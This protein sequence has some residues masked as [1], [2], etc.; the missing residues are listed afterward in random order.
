MKATVITRKA[1]QQELKNAFKPLPQATIQHDF[2][3]RNIAKM[4]AS[5]LLE[6]GEDFKT[7]VEEYLEVINKLPTDSKRALH[8]AYIF[9]RKAPQQERNDLY[10]ELAI[11]LLESR[12][13]NDKLAYSIARCDWK[14]WWRSFKLRNNYN[15]ESIER[16]ADSEDGSDYGDNAIDRQ[17]YHSELLVGE[18]E[19][20]RIADLNKLW[21]LLPDNIKHIVTKRFNGYALSGKD[22]V[23]M[24]RYMKVHGELLAEYR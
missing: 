4:L 14:D 16:L 1:T 9:S 3:Y 18:I 19:V 7:H 5:A 2:T 15:Y 23:A 12:P 21:S 11:R 17:V 6:D 22:R 8:Y 10:Q 20:E 13:I 24:C